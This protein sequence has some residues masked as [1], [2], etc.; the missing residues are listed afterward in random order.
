MIVIIRVKQDHSSGTNL[1][2]WEPARLCGRSQVSIIWTTSKISFLYFETALRIT[3]WLTAR[4]LLQANYHDSDQPS[5][6]T[7]EASVL[8]LQ[9]SSISFKWLW[10]MAPVSLGSLTL[11]SL[12]FNF[13]FF[14]CPIHIWA[15]S[16]PTPPVQLVA[17]LRQ[18]PSKVTVLTVFLPVHRGSACL[19]PAALWECGSSTLESL[20]KTRLPTSCVR[21]GR[22]YSPWQRD[23]C[24]AGPPL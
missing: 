23:G 1:D 7:T 4:H 12:N 21:G 14:S 22:F 13:F 3:I 11:L 15:V 6:V 5:S 24:S 19:S 9:S 8:Q 17:S 16:D 10:S 20:C 2:S 18:H